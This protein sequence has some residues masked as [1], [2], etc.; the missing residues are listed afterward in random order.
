MFLEACEGL[1]RSSLFQGL[2]LAAQVTELG[3]YFGV[4]T[5]V[6]GCGGGSVT[7]YDVFYH[8]FSLG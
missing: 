7:L 4:E 2:L 1:K 3:N 6:F 5:V 8:L